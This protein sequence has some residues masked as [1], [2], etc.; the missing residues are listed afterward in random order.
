MIEF[1]W[2]P[3]K[4][5]QN[6][7]KHRIAFTETATVFG[8]PL[9]IT[10]FAPDHSGAEDRFV[11]VGSSEQGRTLIVAHTDRGNKIRIISARELTP[12]ERKAYEKEIERRA[13]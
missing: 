7:R 8:D 2:D 11:T 13:K 4:A 10:A 5:D 3:K 6:V 9:A 12:T 1:A